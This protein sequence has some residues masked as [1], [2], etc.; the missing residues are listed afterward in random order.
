[1]RKRI[2]RWVSFG[3]TPR[4]FTLRPEWRGIWRYRVY[5]R[6]LFVDIEVLW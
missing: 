3:V 1:M 4:E 5:V 2:P 6:W